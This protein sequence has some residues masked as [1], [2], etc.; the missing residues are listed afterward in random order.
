[1]SNSQTIFDAHMALVTDYG[2]KAAEYARASTGT[3]KLMC[4]KDASYAAVEASARALAAPE[5]PNALAAQARECAERLRL[6]SQT[7]RVQDAC[8][9]LEQCARALAAIPEGF[10]PVCGRGRFVDEMWGNCSLEHVRMVQAAPH[11]WKGYMVEELYARTAPTPPK[12]PT[13]ADREA[14]QRERMAAKFSDRPTTPA[15]ADFDLIA[16]SDAQGELLIKDGFGASLKMTDGFTLEPG[17]RFS[18]RLLP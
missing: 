11:E 1:M 7:R 12:A 4:G 10:V 16:E 17:Q 2:I 8:D 5:Q 3:F 14:A 9:V 18:L 13:Q 6:I 15:T